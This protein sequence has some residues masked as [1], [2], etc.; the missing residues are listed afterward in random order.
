MLIP[1]H[2]HVLTREYAGL[3][4]DRTYA[5]PQQF[6]VK[7]KLPCQNRSLLISAISFAKRTIY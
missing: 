7:K 6:D 2:S 5:F 1:I 4:I 3:G